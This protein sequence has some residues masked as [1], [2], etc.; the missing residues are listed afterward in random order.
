M[1][2]FRFPVLAILAV[3]LAAVRP[4]LAIGARLYN[5]GPIQI[6]VDGRW[7]WFACHDSGRVYVLDGAMRP[8]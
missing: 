1:S 8:S 5:S 6:T 4:L 2:T 3:T 7:V